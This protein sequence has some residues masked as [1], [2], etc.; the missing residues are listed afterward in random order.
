MTVRRARRDLVVKLE[1]RPRCG[2]DRPTSTEF[3]VPTTIARSGGRNY[4]VNAKFASASPATD[5]YEVVKVPKK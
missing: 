4:V 3:D 1:P 5:T 2:D